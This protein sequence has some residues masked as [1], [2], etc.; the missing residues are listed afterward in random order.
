MNG[1]NLRRAPQAFFFSFGPC[2]ARFL[3]FFA[4]KMRKWGVHP[5]V[6]AP[7]AE[8]FSSPPVAGSPRPGPQAVPAHAPGEGA[9]IAS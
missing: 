1:E 8:K 4:K 2:T 6:P 3:N 5:R 9:K 7:W